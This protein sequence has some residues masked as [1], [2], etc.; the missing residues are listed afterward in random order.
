MITGGKIAGEVLDRIIAE[1]KVGVNILDLETLANQLITAAGAE[2][3]FKRVEG[4]HHALCVCVNEEVVHCPPID[5]VLKDGD[6]VTVDLGVYYQGLNTDTAWTV[7]VGEVSTKTKKFL[8]TGQAALRAGMAQARDGNR[9][10]DISAAIE[11]VI[12]SQ[13]YGIVE[14]LTGHGV[15]KDLHEAPMIPNFGKAGSGPALKEGMT[16]AIEPIYTDGDPEIVLEDDDWSIVAP[17]I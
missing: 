12:T 8:E 3:A 10:G 1:T 9:V 4:Y 17:K 13:G 5:R 6:I 7:A 14:T 11:K 15:G 16:I 2:P